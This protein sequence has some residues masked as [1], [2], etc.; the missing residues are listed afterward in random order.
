MLFS[1]SIRMSLYVG[2]SIQKLLLHDILLYD[3]VYQFLLAG[4]DVAVNS[5]MDLLVVF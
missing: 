1:D 5:A 4:L 2:V 3:Y